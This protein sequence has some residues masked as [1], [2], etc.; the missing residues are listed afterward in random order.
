MDTA[1]EADEKRK[2]QPAPR[3][4]LGKARS[5]DV[6]GFVEAR[7][8]EI[9]ALQRSLEDARAAGNV[10][11]FQTLPR[12]LRRRAASH[13]VK[14]IPA[15]LRERAIAE[16]KRSA[17]SSKALAG[18]DRLTNAKRASRYKRRRSRTV[19]DEYELRQAGKRWLETHVWHAKRMHMRELWGTM[20]AET[21]NERSHRVAY[22]A[23]KEK[24]YIQDISF[25]RTLEITGPE[26]AI[27]GLVRRL[28]APGSATL[29]AKPYITG[30]RMAPLALH[31]ADM[32]PLA[33]L[34]P[35]SALWQP[36]ADAGDRRLW[37]RVHPANADAIKAELASAIGSPPG[38]EQGEVR[39]ADVSCDVVSFELLGGQSTQ[40]L[41]TVLA[42]AADPEACGSAALRLVRQVPSPAVLPESVVVALR[43]HDPRL[44]F[45]HKVDPGSV[46]LSD[47]EQRQLQNLLR[48]W[49][50]EA[51]IL[52]HRGGGADHGIW[53]R[54][55]CA[56]GVARRPAEHILNARRQQQ[57]IPGAK[58]VPDPDADVTVPLLL[59]RT[60]PEALVGSRT[61]RADRRCVDT[62]AHGWT[63]LAP[64]GWGMPLW[65]SLGF[66]GGRA[67]GLS[68]RHH[69]GFEAGLPTFP[70]NWPGT[71]AYD[72]WAGAA[73]AAARQQWIRRPPGKRTNYLQL[74]ITSPFY[75][76]FH[77]L[78]GIEDVPS[79]YPRVTADGLEC[80]MR[81]LKKISSNGRSAAAETAQA[82]S[83]DDAMAVDPAPAVQERLASSDCSQDP[84][85]SIWLVAG[86]LLAAAVE[87]QLV[88]G[89]GPCASTPAPTSLLEWA[90]PLLGAAGC[91]GASVPHSLRGQALLER[92]LVR[93]RLVCAGRGVL[94][95]CAPICLHPAGAA[96]PGDGD[97]IGYVM[98][99][100]YSLARGCGM[101]IGACSLR[102]LF[103]LWASPSAG[104]APRRADASCRV[105]VRSLG[106]AP[107]TTAVLTVLP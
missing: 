37:L 83:A 41:A 75:P 30:A 52:R 80:R 62:L 86:E 10:R 99:G 72:E 26:A 91:A 94:A 76:P 34:G 7:A 81:R 12:H 8:F 46:A 19:R 47:N 38:G 95:N 92:C 61:A 11:A 49:P 35:A 13:N 57:L 22:R 45:P 6:V 42:Q 59:V 2:A 105:L 5:V 100:S 27:V 36:A 60:G 64:R 79:V 97:T 3:Y 98:T 103:R 65:M 39:L 28:T 43:I 96:E 78:L 77:E 44:S 29:A 55:A 102:G 53:D 69:V 14:R 85:G 84:S 48:R 87:T 93:V 32:Y 70:A 4:T 24:T 73:A 16:M 63:L 9:N 90:A 101:A 68:E 88:S 15:R 104:E 31:R 89:R 54:D 1:R 25:F 50:T 106:G 82:A 56:Q 23:A 66:A 74:G 21:P 58:L 18:T 51:S 17:Q 40:L 67:Q 107:S 71:V 20:V 33:A